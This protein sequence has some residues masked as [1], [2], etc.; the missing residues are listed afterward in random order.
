M[1]PCREE[2]AEKRLVTIDE[3]VT[4]SV[5]WART[6]VAREGPLRISP[7]LAGIELRPPDAEGVSFRLRLQEADERPVRCPRP[8]QPGHRISVLGASGEG[9]HVLPSLPE[10]HVPEGEGESVS[11]EVP[12]VAR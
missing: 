10:G 11:D 5:I 1:S 7:G 2:R 12:L 4:G 3:L 8:E 9:Q 6:C